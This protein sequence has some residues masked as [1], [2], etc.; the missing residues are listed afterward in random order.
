MSQMESSWR[1]YSLNLIDGADPDVFQFDNGVERTAEIDQL[2]LNFMN[3]KLALFKAVSP[4]RTFDRFA[5]DFLSTTTVQ[6]DER[7]SLYTVDPGG[8]FG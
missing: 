5:L 2:A 7:D 4:S 8:I 6:D 1:R 3:A